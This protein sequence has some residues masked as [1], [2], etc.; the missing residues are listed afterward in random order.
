MSDPPYSFNLWHEPWIRVTR[1][2]GRADELSIG[3]CLAE[4][5]TLA[6]L[7]DPSPLVV[8]G[9]HRLLTAVLQA[10][11]APQDLG[12][13]ADLL[14]H[15]QFDQTRLND[16]AAA[17]SAR[18]DLF[19]PETPFLQTGDVPLDGWKKR[20]YGE[21]K[22][23]AYLFQEVPSGSS[24]TLYHHT[25]DETYW[26]CPA[27]CARGI[28]TIPAF[29]M[30]GGSGIRPSINAD[31]PIYILPAGGDLFESLACSLIVP[32][33]LPTSADPSRSELSIWNNENT[34]GKGREI[35]AVGYLES[36]TF[37]A[38]R[39]RLYP[40]AIPIPSICS[41]CGQPNMLRVSEMLFE[42][43]HWRSK[44][45]LSW[46]DPFIALRQP[47][48]KTKSGKEGPKPIR[49]EAG[50]SFWREYGTLLLVK[51][52]K[53]VLRPKVVAQ[54]GRLIEEHGV[55]GNK[56]F[57]RFRCLSIRNPSGKAV[58][59]EWLDESL[60]AP[61]ALLSDDDA[62]LY[63]DDALQRAD[64]VRFVLESSFD[65]HFRPER[66]RGGRDAKLARFKTVRARM[67]ADYW[68]NLAPLFRRFIADL[69]NTDE[70]EN[71]AR[72]WATTLVREGNQHFVRAA[73]QVGAS[74]EALRSRV[75]AQAECGR[76]LYAKRKEWFG[77]NQ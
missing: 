63:V 26:S 36:L 18:F 59:Y 7:S 33:F 9:V 56:D 25:T 2:D 65:H 5:H 45:T 19:H 51:P 40:Q 6:A 77:D 4:A 42:M 20:D 37:S 58:I 74:A 48:G 41:Q 75:E 30:S 49:P 60:E 23:V 32:G 1:L 29:A 3:A 8:G 31:P 55:L 46:D 68:A 28:V 35:S 76:R 71:V 47:R 43:G 17:H 54:I 15:G 27:C 62:A 38:R 12:A 21:T 10:I 24:R 13:I 70:R 11:Y 14:T 53:S 72:A 22:S 61:P 67:T 66:D 73:E 44:S 50:K 69:A 52:D 64:E 16:F 39:V 57:V 34:I